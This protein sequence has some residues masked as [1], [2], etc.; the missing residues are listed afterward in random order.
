MSF[1]EYSNQQYSF[2]RGYPKT[3]VEGEQGATINFTPNITLRYN[4]T[5]AYGMPPRNESFTDAGKQGLY[6]SQLKP[7]RIY[8]NGLYAPA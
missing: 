1:I 3:L 6:S 8:N 5:Y 4:E 2:W 7:R